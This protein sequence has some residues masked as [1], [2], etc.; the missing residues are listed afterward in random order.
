M[1]SRWRCAQRVGPRRC[2]ANVRALPRERDIPAARSRALIAFASVAIGYVFSDRLMWA[3]AA[4]FAAALGCAAI[5]AAGRGHIVR[6]ALIAAAAAFGAGW[7]SLRIHE[8]PAAGLAEVLS[9]LS[10]K[11]RALI[12][13]RGVVLTPPREVASSTGPLARF[14]IAPRYTRFDLGADSVMMDGGVWR[15]ASGNLWAR[16]AGG[17]PTGVRAGQRVEVTGF[18]SAPEAPTNPGETDL[19]PIA[20]QSA[21]AGLVTLSAPE[22]IVPVEPRPGV[23]VAAQRGWLHA[24]AWLQERA[25]A[26]VDRAA[27]AGPEAPRA[28]LRGLI[29]GDYDPAQREVYNAFARQGLVHVLSISG[30]HLSAMALVALAVIRLSGDRGWLEPVLVAVLVLL[31]M[32]IVPAASP[33]V[34]SGAMVLLILLASAMGRRYDHV[35]LLVWIALGLVLWRPRDLWG[36]GFQL[37]VGLTAALFYFTPIVRGR[38]FGETLR[39]TVRD[40]EHQLTDR[41]KELL[42]DAAAANLLCWALAAPLIA[43]HIGIVSPLAF[44]VSFLVTPLV[45][46]V[47]WVAYPALLIGMFVPALAGGASWLIGFFARS[48]VWLV[49]VADG[50]PGSSVILPPVT[51]WWTFGA[52]VAVGCVLRFGVR[53]GPARRIGAVAFALLV[54]WTGIELFVP[55]RIGADLRIDTFDVGDGTCH[56]IR[57]G[58]DA[59]LWDC[60]SLAGGQTHSRIERAVRALGVRATPRVI[61]THPDIDHFGALLDLVRPLGVREVITCE[62]FFTDAQRDPAGSAAVLLR[63]LAARGVRTYS[64]AAGDEVPLGG[65]VLR[66]ISP[67]RGAA[68][69]I[70]ND[71]SLVGLVSARAAPLAL[72]TGDVQDAAIASLTERYPELSV[73]VLELPHHGS[74]RETAIRWVGDVD[75]RLVI[76]STGP[77]RANDPRWAHLRESRLWRC[78]ATDGAAWVEVSDGA[79]VT[80][81]SGSFVK[82]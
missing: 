8:R 33:I 30:F 21:F 5:A 68:Y 82:P 45:M 73:K 65:L 1:L 69:E 50:V 9:P 78:T 10:G 16:V 38:L 6:V 28:F 71:H 67:E 18:F 22:L 41:V 44:I 24:R 77:R 14:V 34:R 36:M 49:N 72:F 15:A 31:Y 20:A 3:S 40:R 64:A 26:V 52:T 60:G 12:T 80:V 32:A 7:H 70:D 27:G 61:I 81:R 48:A 23:V 2:R 13:V 54:V 74:A 57:S 59:V 37:S 47:L 63:E 11:E 53:R 19:R 4:C 75:P 76:Q 42:K 66:F 79:E 43:Y 55:R 56:L 39:G 62:R 29:L 35:T 51:L 17:V 25:R 58:R 46:L